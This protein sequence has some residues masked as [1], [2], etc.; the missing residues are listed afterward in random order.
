MAACDA[1]VVACGTA[2]LEAALLNTPLVAIY[3][4]APATYFLGKRLRLVKIDRFALPNIVAGRDVVPELIQHEVTPEKIAELLWELWH[5]T[6]RRKQ[7]LT[8]YQEIRTKLGQPG[9]VGRVAQLVLETAEQ[10]RSTR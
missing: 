4:V 6:E 7:M 10:S 2:T 9:A 5:S 1:A 8:D 3:R